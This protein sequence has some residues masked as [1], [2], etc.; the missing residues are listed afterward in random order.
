MRKTKIICTL[1]PA[2]D[3][4]NVLRELM[5][6]GMDVARVNM[7]HQDHKAQKVRIN[8]V[9]KLREEL[10]LPVALLLDTKGPEIRTGVFNPNKVHLEKG[11][12]FTL[13]TEDI[14]G[15]STRCSIS[16]K[17]LPKDVQNGSRILIDDGL[18][19]LRVTNITET[20]IECTVINGGVVSSNKGINVP[21]VRLSMPFISE[22]DRSDIKFAVEEGFEFIA[23]SFTRTA[24]DLRQL[25]A[26]LEKNNCD[27]IRLI[28]KIE[29]AEGVEKIDEIIDQS[30]GIMVARGDLGVEI[31]LEEIPI[32]QKELIKKAYNAGKQVITATQMLDSM[33]KNPRPTRAE[34]T[35]VA[36]AIYDGTSAIMLSG[37]TAAGDYPIEALKTMARIAERTEDDIDYEGRFRKRDILERPNVTSAISHATCTTAHD[38]GAVAIMTVSKSGKTARMISKYRPNCPIISGTTDPTVLRQMNLSWGV[39]P[40][41]MQEKDNTDELFEHVVEVAG[42]HG[43]VKNGDLVVITAGIPLGVS[44]TTNMLKVHLVGDVLVSGNGISNTSVCGNLCV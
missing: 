42:E 32:I 6:N 14:V 1:G 40:L 26:E 34:S 25:K 4:I 19:E 13:T 27:T 43:L 12:T 37:E 3:D 33:M 2:T 31:P 17:D 36:N 11:Q 5:L 16:F 28:A 9:K 38:L 35:D 24:D 7:S 8:A 15:D 30:D 10:K 29:N 21:G 39:I 23:A 41:L 20:D 18:I 22:K 44:G